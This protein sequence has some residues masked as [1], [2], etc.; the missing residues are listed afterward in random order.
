VGLLATKYTMDM[1]FL[2]DRLKD[3]HGI[4]VLLPTPEQRAALHA[5]IIEELTLG[6]VKESSRAALLEM[7]ADLGR[8]GAEA[9]IIGCTELPL[10]A[11]TDDY[12]IPAFDMV[13]LHAEA[14]V[15]KALE[16]KVALTQS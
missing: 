8:R 14:A 2:A 4:D 6:L 12:P 15:R 10:L 7:T 13:S 5:I 16:P 11:A 1:G 3:V 9:A